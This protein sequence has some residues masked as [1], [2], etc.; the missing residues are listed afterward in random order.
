MADTMRLFPDEKLVEVI[1]HNGIRFEVVACPEAL[2]CGALAYA[3][4][5]TDEP[6]IDSLLKR[7]QAHVS[8]EKKQVIHP[9]WSGCISID[10]WPGGS[11]PRG[12]MFMQQVATEEQ[13]KVHDVYRTPASLYIRAW[14]DGKG[15]P[16]DL[17]FPIHE[18]AAQNGY[19]PH[20]T[21]EAEIEFYGK[22]EACAYCAVKKAGDPS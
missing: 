13:D 6:D 21:G 9:E 19:A 4:N 8:V 7:Y 2:W 17:F 20:A 15:S 12:M 11:T 1:E 14:C 16:F 22:N 3:Q 18:A 10:Y 5:C